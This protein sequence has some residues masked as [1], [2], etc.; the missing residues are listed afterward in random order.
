MRCLF[1]GYQRE[2]KEGCEMAEAVDLE[3]KM[4]VM[5]VRISEIVN[6][7]ATKIDKLTD[8]VNSMNI[9]FSDMKN[10]F[11]G[12]EEFKTT[13]TDYDKQFEVAKIQ[14]DKE[15]EKVKSGQKSVIRS[16]VTATVALVVFLLQ[17]LF[18]IHIKVGGG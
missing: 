15:L 13:C 10:N 16:A 18:N 5:E 11:V 1:H 2:G 9:A 4:A 14:N 12:K 8:S 3:V 7:L 17:Q 6:P